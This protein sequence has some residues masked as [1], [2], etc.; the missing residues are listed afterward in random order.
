MSWQASF[1]TKVFFGRGVVQEQAMELQ[2][3]GSKA[4]I[5]TGKG[6]SSRRNG[7]L[8]D[9]CAALEKASIEW[10]IF[11]EVEANPSVGNVRRGSEIA[12]SIKADFV[13]GVGGGSPID[14]AKGI[15]IVRLNEIS[16][17]DLFNLNYGEVLPIVA[18]PT[19]A[20]TGTE[21]T[22][23]SILTSDKFQT[24]IGIRS[25]SLIPKIAYLDPA[26]TS[27]MPWQI[28]ADTAVDAYSHAIESYLSFKNTPLSTLFS[29]KAL[30]ILGRELK[31][32]AQ[33]KELKSKNRDALMYGSYLAGMAISLTGV[34]IPHAI[35]YSLTYF[36]GLSHGQANG[37]VL[38][39]WLEFNVKKSQS[40][41]ITTALKASS[42]QSVDE[43]HY[44]ME[45][46]CGK[47][48]VSTVEE[49]NLFVEQSLQSKNMYNNIVIPQK[50]DVIHI[51]EH[52][53]G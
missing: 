51:I 11:D 23:A 18:V 36:K 30:H 1:P 50:E 22:S 29:E 40:P 35:G 4:L 49:R 26:Y 12:R 15:A 14:A 46:L 32:I 25:T 17:E 10:E 3:L 5:V 39:A 48:P 2:T 44:L 52:C 31:V 8:D 37:I 6:G 38:P 33:K 9:V 27:Q 53:L 45:I 42:L 19:T 21:V 13:I 16:D 20:G 41:R 28:T 7:A 43:L 34:S 24:K 47:P